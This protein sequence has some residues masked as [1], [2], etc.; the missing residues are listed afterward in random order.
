MTELYCNIN[1]LATLD[2]FENTELKV[3]DCSKNKLIR[4][5]LSENRAL[6]KL[7]CS[8]NSLAKLDLSENTALHFCQH[9]KTHCSCLTYPASRKYGTWISISRTMTYR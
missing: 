5:D 7:D 9:G 6:A 4:L 3:L 8:R 2:L 1:E